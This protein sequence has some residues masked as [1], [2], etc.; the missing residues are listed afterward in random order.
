MAKKSRRKENTSRYIGTFSLHENGD[1]VGD[2][3][4]CGANTLLKLHSDA[5]LPHIQPSACITGTSYTG[6]CLTLID[7]HSPGMGTTSFADAPTKY[8]AE[9]FPH[10]VAVGRRHFDPYA[11]CVSGIHFSTT[12]LTTIFYD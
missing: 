8:H 7:C 4:L 9:V 3:E 11:R 2:L 12:D 6:D 1:V 5:P 10:Y